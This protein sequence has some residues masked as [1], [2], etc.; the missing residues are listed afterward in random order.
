MNDLLL[1]NPASNHALNNAGSLPSSSTNGAERSRSAEVENANLGQRG[2]PEIPGAVARMGMDYLLNNREEA[3]ASAVTAASEAPKAPDGAGNQADGAAKLGFRDSPATTGSLTTGAAPTSPPLDDSGRVG[4]LVDG[5]RRPGLRGS[6]KPEQCLARDPTSPKPS[7]GGLMQSPSPSPRHQQ[8]VRDPLFTP[9]ISAS[10]ATAMMGMLDPIEPMFIPEGGAT[11]MTSMASGLMY[12]AALTSHEGSVSPQESQAAD[13]AAVPRSGEPLGDITNATSTGGAVAPQ[14]RRPQNEHHQKIPQSLGLATN[15]SGN[16]DNGPGKSP[17]LLTPRTIISSGSAGENAA[18]YDFRSNFDALGYG[19]IIGLQHPDV[20]PPSSSPN[21]PPPPHQEQ[22]QDQHQRK[23]DSEHPSTDER[24]QTHNVDAPSTLDCTAKT[25]DDGGGMNIDS[26]DSG[27]ESFWQ[28]S[29]LDLSV[30]PQA[31]PLLSIPAP[32]PSMQHQLHTQPMPPPQFQSTSGPGTAGYLAQIPNLN[33]QMSAI[34]QQIAHL[35]SL[36][37]GYQQP[38]PPDSQNTLPTGGLSNINPALF[39]LS[40]ASGSFTPQF[41]TPATTGTPLQRLHQQQAASQQFYEQQIHPNMSNPYQRAPQTARAPTPAGRPRGRRPTAKSAAAARKPSA[42]P[43]SVARG[44]AALSATKKPGARRAKPVGRQPT[45]APTEAAHAARWPA[46]AHDGAG[47]SGGA[48]SE[49]GSAGGEGKRLFPCGQCGFVF[50]MRSNLKRHI[51]TV[52][53]DR[54]G[55]RCGICAASFGLKQNLVTHVRVKHER[56]RPFAC[57]TCGLTFG[58][59]Q[60]LQNH[61]RNIHA[62]GGKRGSA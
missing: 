21:P 42:T 24:P 60:V 58:Y 25:H 37:N 9:A 35:S 20:L 14:R 30:L 17:S 43:L 32:H 53:E 27:A 33:T 55:F 59:K 7:Q 40:T 22:H 18:T 8:C 52:H 47:S 34:S 11:A 6:V 41:H 46:A 48:G 62:N 3:E 10:P 5:D 16:S 13:H 44:R 45:A 36:A 19:P 61:V 54:R 49:G 56:R 31:S 4:G 23:L 26:P 57:E 15:D 12:S 29:G 1:A 38:Y 50:G 2:V 28:N 39:H 51:S